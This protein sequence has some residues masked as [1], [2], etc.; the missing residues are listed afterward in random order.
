[1]Q[2]LVRVVVMVVMYILITP[3]LQVR[4][5]K[6]GTYLHQVRGL[7]SYIFVPFRFFFR[8]V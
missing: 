5:K 1:M 6:R 7:L 8:E 4:G 2:K 3:C